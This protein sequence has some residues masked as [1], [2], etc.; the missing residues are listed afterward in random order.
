MSERVA[1]HT[2]D[3]DA[4]GLPADG[5]VAATDYS[6]FKHGDGVIAAAYG[7]ALADR[8][9]DVFDLSEG[10]IAV[11]SAGY[12]AVPPAARSLVRP[13][14]QRL[15]ELAPE[16]TATAFRMHRLGVSP[17]DYAAMD[18]AARA[19][20]VSATSMHLDPRINLTGRRVV[21]LDDIRVT[22]THEVAMDGCL[23]SAGAS[24]IDHLYLVDAH[25]CAGNPQIESALNTA[26]VRGV[27]QVLHIASGRGFEPNARLAKRVAVMDRGDQER[28]VRAAPRHAVRWVA[29]A[30]AADRLDQ[31][32]SYVAGVR[33]FRQ[34]LADVQRL[35]QPA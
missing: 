33:S 14:V 24:R 20:A 27:E 21:A 28:F 12:A 5:L 8:F 18:A 25:A 29:E 15:Q 23:T 10:R 31:V 9:M 6:R 16:V 7:R 3:A 17:G 34:V 26:W 13:F 35:S 32:R 2:L 19:A 22:G 4:R 1:L 11:T 30:M